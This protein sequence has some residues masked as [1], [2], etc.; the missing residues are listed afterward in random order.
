M[1]TLRKTQPRLSRKNIHCRSYGGMNL[2]TADRD[3][4]YSGLYESAWTAFSIELFFCGGDNPAMYCFRDVDAAG[5]LISDYIYHHK[6]V[7]TSS[8]FTK[9]VIPLS[10][11]RFTLR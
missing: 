10:K 4:L 3:V 6:H 5:N 11:K 9:A 8:V 2:L 1:L 7:R